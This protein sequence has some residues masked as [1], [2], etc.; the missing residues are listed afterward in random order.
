MSRISLMVSGS[1]AATFVFAVAGCEK[2]VAERP[3][4][5]P[6]AVEQ[7]ADRE[8]AEAVEV[9]QEPD[10][11]PA[12][13]ANQGRT[14][15]VEPDMGRPTAWHNARVGGMAKY[16]MG[17]STVAYEVVALDEANTYVNM[18][19]VV[20]GRATPAR[21]MVMPR[22]VPELTAPPDAPRPEM[23][24]LGVE[25]IRVGDV[26]LVCTVTESRMEIPGIDRAITTRMWKSEKIPGGVVRMMSD[27]TGEMTVQQELIECR[28]AQ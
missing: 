3:D 14:Y 21:Q 19:M 15:R 4:P 8:S 28:I 16:D 9:V 2:K 17:G 7:E 24:D 26:E 12:A 27:A 13:R 6:P 23:K 22:F 18:T 5:E 20:A 25:T 10:S 11:P 1:L